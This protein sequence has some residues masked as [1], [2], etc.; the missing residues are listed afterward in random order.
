MTSKYY[1]RDKSISGNL[2][3]RI[4]RKGVTVTVREIHHTLLLRV[5]NN[6]KVPCG[7][8]TEPEMR[9]RD[10]WDEQHVYSVIIGPTLI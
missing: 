3:F 6:D 5:E 7:S 1:Y 9:S 10:L 8:F 2:D 4:I